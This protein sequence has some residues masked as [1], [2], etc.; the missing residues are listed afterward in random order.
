[1]NASP[2]STAIVAYFTMEIALEASMPTYAGGLGVLAGDT[3][4]AAA[5]LK[6]PMT[7]V[8]LLH[9]RGYFCQ[10][11]DASGWQREESCT[12]DIA[13]HLEEQLP[14]ISVTIES[15]TVQVRAWKYEVKS[16]AGFCVPVFFLDTDLPENSEWDRTL[17]HYLYGGESYYRICQEVVLGIGGVRM[18]RALG[19]NGLTRYHMNEGHAALLGLELLDE[20][21]RRAGRT[22]IQHEDVES[23]RRQCVF[24]THT[25]V[26]SGHDQFPLDLAVRVLGRGEMVAMKEVF[27][28]DGLLNMTFLALNF[29]HYVNGVAKKHAETS[30][31]MFA[32]HKIDSITN[33]VL[34]ATWTSPPFQELFDRHIPGWR[35]D[36]FS[37]RFAHSLP[38]PEI[39]EAHLAAK[40]QLLARV[41]QDTGVAL[42]AEVFTLGFARRATAYKRSDLLVSDTARLNRIAADAG[43]VQIIYGGK[44]HPN[45]HQGKETIQR[46]IQV[47]QQLSQDVRLV[48]LENYDTELAKLMVAGVDVWLNTP[49][50]PMEASGTSGM[51]AALNGVPSLSILDGWWVEGWIE[52]ETGWAISES[53]QLELT[54]DGRAAADAASLYDKLEHVVIPLFYRDPDRFTDVMRH[55]ISLNGSFFNTQRMV[56]QYVIKAY[57]E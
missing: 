54:H 3:V 12:W 46:I 27:C 7:A 40:R 1:V 38:L 36:N 52:G 5:E 11:I 55:S 25:P 16:P 49:Q 13:A 22:T 21:A 19:G 39:R 56:S 15:R 4:R 23:V 51:K 32:P 20:A 30:Q 42:E 10:K 29:S 18:L 43:P 26:A 45:D 6:V 14:R 2:L 17:T 44:A 47:K 28:C 53:C 24:T 37:L 50:P 31:L 9:R 57:F 41:L 34:V 48:F 33:G 8:T 35:G